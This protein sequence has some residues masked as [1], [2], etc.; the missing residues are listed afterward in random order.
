[1]DKDG[2]TT[3][4]RHGKHNGKIKKSSTTTAEDDASF[5]DVTDAETTKQSNI[6]N[7][8]ANNN[9]TT[10]LNKDGSTT[11]DRNGNHN[12]TITTPST[13]TNSTFA[14]IPKVTNTTATTTA[15]ATT[16]TPP[17]LTSNKNKNKNSTPTST[18]TQSPF[19]DG[20][21]K[22][23]NIKLSVPALQSVQGPFAANIDVV[24]DVISQ[25]HSATPHHPAVST[26]LSFLALVKHRCGDEVQVLS[27][28]THEV[29]TEDTFRFITFTATDWSNTFNGNYLQRRGGKFNVQFTLWLKLGGRIKSIGRIKELLFTGLTEKEIYM[30]NSL[31]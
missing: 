28:V 27:P 19:L 6:T 24:D 4:D 11:V 3:V 21:M 29:L 14:G 12:G 9:N 7:T 13:T 20:S 18:P 15:T 1:M 25:S 5:V 8:T 17:T 10:A 16:T 26:L 2:F 23:I 22:A 31:G 30:T